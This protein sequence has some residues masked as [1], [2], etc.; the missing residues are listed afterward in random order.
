MSLLDPSRRPRITMVYQP[1]RGAATYVAAAAEEDLRRRRLE[2]SASTC[3]SMRL[4]AL[5]RGRR[6]RERE[7]ERERGLPK[8]GTEGGRERE[9]ESGTAPFLHRAAAADEENN[10][11]EA[12]LP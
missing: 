6:E 8:G 4:H 10:V 1:Q 11:Q 3:T 12:A 7:R 9:G 5:E 2:G